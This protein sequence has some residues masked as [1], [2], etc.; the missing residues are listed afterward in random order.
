MRRTIVCFLCGLALSIISKPTQAAPF[1][2][3]VQGVKSSTG[4]IIIN[5]FSSPES[6]D[7]QVSDTDLMIAP[8]TIGTTSAVFDLPPGEY[9]FFI[10]HDRNGDG[11]LQQNFVGYPNEPFAFSNN[12]VLRFSKPRYS[13]MKFTIPPEGATQIIQLFDR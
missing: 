12:V 4:A 2:V 5:L 8:V 6:W 10:Y 3:Q 11:K 13:D 7:R 1:K 9:A